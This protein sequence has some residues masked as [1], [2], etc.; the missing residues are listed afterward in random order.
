MTSTRS[1]VQALTEHLRDALAG[2][3]VTVAT[4]TPNPRP[5][6]L[7]RATVVGMHRVSRAHTGTDIHLEAWAPTPAAAEELGRAVFDATET[8]DRDGAWVPV[9]GGWVGGPAYLEDP[10]TG[11]PR[12]VMTATVLQRNTTH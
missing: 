8:L 11:T 10:V 12:Y 6:H 4:T 1:A 5:D 3:Q 7:V 2:H 9:A